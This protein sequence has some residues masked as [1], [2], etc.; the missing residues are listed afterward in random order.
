[1]SS[2]DMVSII[3]DHTQ[4]NTALQ[5]FLSDTKTEFSE[6]FGWA[7]DGRTSRYAMIIDH[8]KI[9]YAEKEPAKEVTVRQ[10]CPNHAIMSNISTLG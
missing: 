3:S 10:A 4:S 8:G 6:K 1:M 2:S 7:S 5:L 9:V